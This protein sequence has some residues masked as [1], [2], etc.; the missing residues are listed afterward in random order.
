LKRCWGKWLNYTRYGFIID[1]EDSEIVASLDCIYITHC[2]D[3]TAVFFK[4]TAS[5]SIVP[6]MDINGSW[7]NS[8]ESY[9][10]HRGRSL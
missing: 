10:I 1:T 6:A 3:Q 5:N 7:L 9:S 8:F 2:C 4:E